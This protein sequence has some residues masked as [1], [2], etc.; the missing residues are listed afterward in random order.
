ML[1]GP[2]ELAGGFRGAVGGALS[3][4]RVRG[5]LFIQ[6]VDTTDWCSLNQ[7]GRWQPAF[8]GDIKQNIVENTKALY[9]IEAGIDL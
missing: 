7:L 1:A 8:K 2:Q 4:L 5:V 3:Q 6:I 9:V